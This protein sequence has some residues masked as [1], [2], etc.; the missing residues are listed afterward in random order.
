MLL[1]IILGII[2]ALLLKV[3][4]DI[5]D[6]KEDLKEISD[7]KKKYKNPFEETARTR[8][9]VEDFKKE[10]IKINDVWYRRD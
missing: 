4:L 8:Q 5:S 9:A 3:A 2:S 7:N 6:I 10:N 1:C